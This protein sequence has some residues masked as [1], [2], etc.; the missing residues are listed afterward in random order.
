MEQRTLDNQKLEELHQGT[1]LYFPKGFYGYEAEKNLIFKYNE[2]EK[3]F[4]HLENQN[5]HFILIQSYFFKEESLLPIISELDLEKLK[6]KN[7][8]E[9]LMY[10]IVTIP[11]DQPEE[12]TANL[13]A[14]ICINPDAKIGY[15]FIS[16]KETSLLRMKILSNIDK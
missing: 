10:Y 13:Q 11:Q 6:I 7:L 8:S 4:S 1:E 16:L 9:C 5:L 2:N 14:P 12:M 15:Q 3:P